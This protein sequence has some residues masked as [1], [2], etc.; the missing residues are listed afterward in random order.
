[1]REMSLN[2]EPTLAPPDKITEEDRLA[3][4]NLYLRLTNLKLQ[5]DMC[6]A[7]KLD[8][9]RKKIEAV[10]QMRDLQAQLKKKQAE[11]SVKYGVPMGP[12]AIGPDG[13]IRR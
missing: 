11:L 3:V 2:D 4:E 6:D 7:Q 10:G 13:S 9:E 8:L 1:M 5:C 12:E